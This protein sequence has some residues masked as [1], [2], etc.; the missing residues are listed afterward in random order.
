MDALVRES[1][2]ELVARLEAAAGDVG[3][4]EREQEELHD[5]GVVRSLMR[6]AVQSSETHVRISASQALILCF[7]QQEK[8]KTNSRKSSKRPAAAAPRV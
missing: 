1:G 8:S 6:R 4:A 5:E 7:R 2:V 3:A